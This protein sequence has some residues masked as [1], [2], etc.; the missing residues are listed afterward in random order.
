M[1]IIFVRQILEKALKESAF[2]KIDY[3]SKKM[4]ITR[5]R[6]IE[7]KIL[8]ETMLLAEET[9]TGELKQFSLEG[10]QKIETMLANEL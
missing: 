10:I 2:L 6:I 4:V 7:P 8:K 1:N 5:D 3:V 9:K